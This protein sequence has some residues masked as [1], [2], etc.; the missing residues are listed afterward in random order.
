MPEGYKT[1]DMKAQ[2]LKDI[3]TTWNIGVFYDD[4]PYNVEAARE[5]GVNA[6]LVP[7]NEEFWLKNGDGTVAPTSRY[8]F[9]HLQGVV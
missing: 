4:S 7:G 1:S 6:R 9:P 3:R 8:G 2:M 5:L